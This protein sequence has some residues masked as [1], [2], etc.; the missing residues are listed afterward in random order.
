M[1]IEPLQYNERLFWRGRQN[2][3]AR[4]VRYPDRKIFTWLVLRRFE[5]GEF[6]F[7]AR[8]VGFLRAAETKELLLTA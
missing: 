3:H 5:L 7:G 8:D 2:Q 1:P 4:R 6:L